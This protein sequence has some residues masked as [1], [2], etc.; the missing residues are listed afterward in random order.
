MRAFTNEELAIGERMFALQPDS[1]W[2]AFC[3]L[4]ELF[5]SMS[6]ERRQELHDVVAQRRAARVETR[7]KA[8]MAPFAQPWRWFS[9]GA[10][11]VMEPP[12]GLI[13]AETM[14]YVHQHA[15]AHTVEAVFRATPSPGVYLRFRLRDLPPEVSAVPSTPRTAQKES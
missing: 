2:T 1:P 7:V 10:W 8:L 11:I 15:D 12:Q 5:G 9:V 3:E 13:A 6:L 14:Q 4:R